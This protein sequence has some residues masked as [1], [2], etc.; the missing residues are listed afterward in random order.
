MK[1]RLDAERC[2]GH[3]QCYSVDPDM[4]PV[5]DAGYC[6]LEAHVV[7]PGDEEIARAGVQ[8]CPEQALVLDEC[9]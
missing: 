9:T 3:A 2:V 4:F 8:A 5:D 1:I 7:S 6:I